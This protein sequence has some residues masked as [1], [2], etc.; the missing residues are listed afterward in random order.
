MKEHSILQKVWLVLPLFILLFFVLSFSYRSD[1]SFSQDLGRHLRLGEVIWNGFSV[2]KNNLFSYTFPDFEFVNHHWLFEVIVYLASTAIGMQFVLG[3]KILLLLVAV[4]LVLLIAKNTG[5]VF[6]IPVSFLFLHML[7]SRIDLR[8]EIFSFLFTAATYYI[9]EKFERHDTKLIYILPFLSLLWVNTHIYYPVGFILQLI[10]LSHYLIEKYVKK[11]DNKKIAKKIKTLTIVTVISLLATFVNPNFIQG[12]LYA[13]NVFKN[14]GVTI[15]ENQTMATLQ[16]TGFVNPDFFFAYFCFLMI[17]LA[18]MVGLMRNK[19]TFKNMSLLGLGLVLSIQSI[20]GF[21]YLVFLCLPIILIYLDYKK[22]NM[23]VKALNIFVCALLFIE[24]F[25]YLSGAYYKLTYRNHTVSL[26]AVEDAKPAM[27]FVL[28]HHLPQPLFNNFDI[29]SYIIYRSY[30][31]YKVFIDGRPEA[32]PARFFEETYL[33]MQE[34]YEIFQKIHKKT[35]FKTVIF[36]LTDQN[37]RTIKFLRAITNDPQWKIVYLDHF[38]IVLV[39]NDT[40]KKLKLS[41]IALNSLTPENYHYTD[42]AAYTNLSTFLFNM[43]A[44]EKAKLFNQKALEIA[45][46]NPAA[47]RIMANILLQDKNPNLGLVHE[48]LSKTQN[49]VF[50]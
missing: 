20:R 29:G 23:W 36:S 10:F 12:A 14:Y 6:F 7:R 17:A 32:Y 18:F 33:P 30:P 26:Q 44:F 15:S 47:N 31:E 50:W 46:N 41:P 39:Q 4:G 9:L 5:S 27:D 2:P 22:M 24:A 3:I 49:G 1:H 25:Y 11:Q 34:N 45:P 42:V 40:V 19:V 28:A 35:G 21:P 16:S 8:P 38:M 13:F 37:P 43:Y 48:Y